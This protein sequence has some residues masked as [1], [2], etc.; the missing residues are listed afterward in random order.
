M[1]NVAG[2]GVERPFSQAWRQT[3][4]RKPG[5]A[6]KGA[7]KPALLLLA[8]LVLFA[9][10]LDASAQQLHP[11]L[12][13]SEAF[14]TALQGKTWETSFTV[15]PRIRF[16]TDRIEYL[17]DRGQITGKLSKV[18]YPEPGFA[19][20]EFNDGSFHFFIFS[21]DLESF[22]IANMKD[23]SEFKVEG[24][25]S[26][27]TLPMTNDAAPL[28]LTFLDNP[29]WKAARLHAGKLEVLDGSGA[30]FA[31]NP[32]FAYS[33]QTHGVI[34][35]QK[36]FGAVVLS[37]QKPGGGW[38]LSGRNLGTGVRT[39]VSGYFRQFLRTR[40]SQFPLWSAHFNYSLLQAG[41]EQMA[42]GQE[43]FALQLAVD[44][45]GEN[46]DLVA[47]CLQEMGKLRGYARSYE[48]AAQLHSQALAKARVSLAQ[49]KEALLDIGTDLAGSQ[50]D[51]GAFAAAKQTLADI[52]GMLPAPGG[53]IAS[54][55]FFYEALGTAEFGLRNYSQAIKLFADNLKRVQEA[56]LKGN[57][58]SMQLS[59][60]AAYLASGQTSAA[61]G[62]LKQCLEVQDQWQKENPTYNF[63]TWK[64]AFACVA[65]G[66][67]QEALKYAPTKQRRNWVAYEEY[68]RLVS[69]LHGGDRAAAQTLAKEFVGRF[70]NIQEI[71]IR[72]DIDPITVKL[73][74][75][76]ADPTPA[77]IAALEQIWAGQV[78]SLRNRPLKNYLFARVMVLT[79]AKLKGK[80]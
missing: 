62:C 33:S 59:L 77:K 9:G 43:A 27:T 31:T 30:V 21:D 53:N 12:R 15:Y 44:R 54:T 80:G 2:V 11:G 26:P 79:L 8:L 63:D 17:D 10:L 69:L 73:T 46:S 60:V 37:R 45:H 56:N 32:S 65:L 68:G 64:L 76:I 71:N 25:A 78:D 4:T 51:A 55:Y 38:Y 28:T 57:M 40:L 7:M 49:D 18:S 42:S 19:K 50:N 61:E 16:E 14:L 23:M 5:I 22:V 72:D 13:S 75:A 67:N 36:Q 3:L 58:V 48:K 20:A 47:R 6:T 52:Y 35:P 70:N 24:S 41:K 29:F 1:G 74:E 34:L 39:D 66:K